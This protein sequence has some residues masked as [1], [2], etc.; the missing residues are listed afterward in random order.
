MRAT[1]HTPDFN[2]SDS[3]LSFWDH[4][5][6]LRQVLLRAVILLAMATI[7]LFCIM[8]EFF[9]RFILAP[10]RPD[11]LTYRL[12]DFICQSS[13]L[14]DGAA[15]STPIELVNINLSSQFMIHLSASFWLATIL[16]APALLVILWQFIA[17]ALY[18][19]ERR[20]CATA[21]ISGSVMFY[22]G[23]LASYLLIFP[24]TLRFLAGYQLSAMVPNIIS[25]ES[26]IDTLSGLT[27]IMGLTF[28]LPLVAWT[29]GRLGLITRSI[30]TRFRR[31]AI[32]ALLVLAALI[33]PTGDPLTLTVV[34]LPL[35]LLWELSALAVP[36]HRDTQESYDDTHSSSYD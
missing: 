34:F 29:A 26:Y 22:L 15:I 8:P 13:G 19:N 2:S 9:D 14:T 11:F 18:R 1:H 4:L 33:T 28:E 3:G 25:L 20:A 30:F 31:H 7:G 35:Y 17:P 21:L 27:L 6:A 16:S 12:L 32:V 23:V 24:L 36:T 5:E 10:C